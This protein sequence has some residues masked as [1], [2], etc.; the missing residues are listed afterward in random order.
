M[1]DT[2]EFKNSDLLS[3]LKRIKTTY[4]SNLK[5]ET[6]KKKDV[7]ET[8]VLLYFFLQKGKVLDTTEKKLSNLRLVDLHANNSV[9]DDHLRIEYIIQ[10]LL[11]NLNNKRID[12]LYEK[13][14][15]SIVSITAKKNLARIMYF[16][17]MDTCDAIVDKSLGNSSK[18]YKSIIEKNTLSVLSRR[19][20]N[21]PDEKSYAKKLFMIASSLAENE[22]TIKGDEQ[23]QRTLDPHSKHILQ[24]IPDII[25]PRSLFT[26]PDEEEYRVT[27]AMSH[28]HSEYTV[29]DT[30]FPKI[31]EDVDNTTINLRVI[32][33]IL[34]GHGVIPN[35]TPKITY[36]EEDMTKITK[37]IDMLYK[38]FKIDPGACLQQNQDQ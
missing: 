13:E 35:I 21:T 17:A 25:D 10:D 24:F 8:M 18:Q 36:L 4:R 19:I 2:A 5:D 26:K 32:Q 30:Q 3:A 31:K 29:F 23:Q 11:V 38:A 33:T 34:I 14:S 9:E 22:V 16:I 6:L 28:D 12:G 37:T 15:A 7:I 20:D 27:N 1:S